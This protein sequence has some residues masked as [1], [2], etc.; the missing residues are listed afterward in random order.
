MSLT[1]VQERVLLTASGAVAALTGSGIGAGLGYVFSK[2]SNRARHQRMGVIVGATV[3]SALAGLVYGAPPLCGLMSSQAEKDEIDRVHLPIRALA[4]VGG[5]T[6][7]LIG[8]MLG[9]KASKAHP[10]IGAVVGAMLGSGAVMATVA[11]TECP[12]LPATGVGSLRSEW[13][14]K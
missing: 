9:S 12:R 5:G 10:T 13:G 7:A 1:P 14:L 11:T 4:A 6:A 3:N 2:P 8:G